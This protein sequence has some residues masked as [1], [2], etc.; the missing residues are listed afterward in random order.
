LL[1]CVGLGLWWFGGSDS[2]PPDAKEASQA[3]S[4]PRAASKIV[5]TTRPEEP[6]ARKPGKRLVKRLRKA[7]KPAQAG[8][9]ASPEELEEVYE[10]VDEDEALEEGAGSA[11]TEAAAST[12]PA[13][14]SPPPA[15]TPAPPP[16]AQA[17]EPLPLPDKVVP[18][19]PAAP[20][21]AAQQPSENVPAQT[22]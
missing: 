16:A 14:P 17:A 11:A 1:V 12:Q 6:Q 4:N 19:N 21:E 13:P 15:E 22:H 18:E 5:S 7:K 20:V 2:T 3:A 8:A 10:E 9:P